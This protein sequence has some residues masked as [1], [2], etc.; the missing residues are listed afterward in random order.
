MNLNHTRSFAFETGFVILMIFLFVHTSF[1]QVNWMTF[2]EAEIKYQ[3]EKRKI[4]VDVYTDWCGW[5]KKMDANTFNE[6]DISTYLNDNFYPVKFDAEQKEAI[7]FNGREYKYIKMGR[8]GYNE[9]ALEILK[10]KLGYPSIV[11]MDENLEVIQPIEGY[12]GPSVFKMIMTYFAGDFH[13]TVPWKMYSQ[14]YD[15][16]TGMD[17]SK[18]VKH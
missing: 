13:K 16:N 14:S 2:E 7:S 15:P 1:G 6:E 9:L 5:C 12:K 10:G 18:V 4:F 17:Y 11:F 8:R 3:E